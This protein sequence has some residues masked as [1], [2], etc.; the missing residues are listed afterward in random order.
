MAS[1]RIFS[2]AEVVE[3]VCRSQ[4]PRGAPKPAQCRAMWEDRL[5]GKRYALVDIRTAKLKT[6]HERKSC[7]YGDIADYIR[8]RE[9]GSPFPPVLLAGW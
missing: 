1:S 4:Q 6:T 5:K 2:G 3:A 9:R 7:D 8:L